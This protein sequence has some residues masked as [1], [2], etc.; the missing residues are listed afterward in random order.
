MQHSFRARV[1]E[2]GIF[3]VADQR[4]VPRLVE[5]EITSR[6]PT[7]VVVDVF[8]TT[9]PH[10]PGDGDGRFNVVFHP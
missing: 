2:P 10:G 5:F 9:D 4:R 8:A 6:K 7:G 1:V 3:N